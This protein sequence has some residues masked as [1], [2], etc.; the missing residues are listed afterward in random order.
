MRVVNYVRSPTWTS[1]NL[2]SEY[3]KDGHNFEY[4]EEEKKKY[5]ED[6]NALF[7]LRKELEAKYDFPVQHPRLG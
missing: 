5:G 4:S 2:M 3:A 7:E 1:L 6:Q